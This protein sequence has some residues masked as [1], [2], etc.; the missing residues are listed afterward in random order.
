MTQEYSIIRFS[1]C[2][3]LVTDYSKYKNKLQV[4]LTAEVSFPVSAAKHCPGALKNL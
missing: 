4:I 3:S 2:T 1:S